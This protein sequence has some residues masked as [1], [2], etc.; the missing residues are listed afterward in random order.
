M[1]DWLQQQP[2][3]QRVVT[4]LQ[5]QQS[6][7]YLVG[8]A[9]RDLLLGRD[10][11]VDLD[12]A[13]PGDGLVVARRVAN[14]LG[15]A[16]Y[17]LDAE[18]G[19]GRVVYEQATGEIPVKTYLD[20]ATF[21]GQTLAQ[22]LAD[23]DFTINAMALSL[24]EAPELI[25]PLHG[26]ADLAAGRIRAASPAAFQNDPVRVLRAARQATEFGFSLAVETETLIRQAA[27]G[28]DNVSAER[29]RDELVKLLNTP[30]PGQAVRLLNKLAVLPH[31]L[32]EVVAM[33]G[34]AQS[35]PHYL[36]VF[37]HT[38]EAL[39]VWAGLK[40]SGLPGLPAHLREAVRDYLAERLAGE[41][42]LAQALP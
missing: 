23:R 20:F 31:F 37:E 21:R 7:A 26:Q 5:A 38:A 14:A 40:E 15:A 42:S 34:V 29:K 2:L 41:F 30:A 27:P 13:V 25:D 11:V 9:V 1:R 6:E 16:F 19:T 10:Q 39:N 32:P 35:P 22:D 17:P 33:T 24:A 4:I 3:L 12:F 8:G 18:R 28:L 36:D